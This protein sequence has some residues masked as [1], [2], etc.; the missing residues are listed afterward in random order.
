MIK[1]DLRRFQASRDVILDHLCLSFI[2]IAVRIPFMG[3][4]G[5]DAY[6]TFRYARNIASGFGFV[7][8]PGEQVLGTSTPL[9]ALLLALFGWL[10][11]DLITVAKVI[12]ILAEAATCILL[13]VTIR[14]IAPRSLALIGAGLFI[15]SPYNIYWTGLGM[16][17]GLY[18]L[19]IFACLFLY[20][21]EQWTYLGIAAGLLTLVRPDGWLVVAAITG[22][23]VIQRKE[24]RHALKP[25]IAL[26]SIQA[27]W[28]TFAFFYFGSPLPQS[29]VAKFMSYRAP[30]ILSWFSTYLQTFSRG[31]S[32]G[33]LLVSFLFLAGSISIFAISSRRHLVPFVVWFW[34]YVFAF[35]IARAGRFGWYYSPLMPSLFIFVCLGGYDVFR[36]ARTM[37]RVEKA[38]STISQ[39]RLWILLVPPVLLAAGISVYGIWQDTQIER[40]CEVQLSSP[41]GLWLRDNTP[42]A[43]TV[44][45]ESIGSVG[46]FSNRYI[47][48]EAGLVSKSTLAENSMT[49]GTVNVV[50]ILRTLKP[51]YYIAW[52]TWEL[53]TLLDDPDSQTWLR[54][55]YDELRR[56][57]GCGKTWVLFGKRGLQGGW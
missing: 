46:W 4:T 5:D 7:Y 19:L 57:S 52:Q 14:Q 55:N 34:L 56:Y 17:T 42:P 24:M 23:W 54:D 38:L 15:L 6:I 36:R 2:T 11:L 27:P 30:E 29:V 12:N 43:A 9:F 16:E 25:L 1:L 26:F 51:D 20:I 33:T 28:L 39:S 41:V 21:R 10:G 8:N 32:F 37:P 47:I 45:L 18:T 3:A 49:P 40:E 48:D 13:Y 53:D 22:A 31:G 35:T 50:G 44:S